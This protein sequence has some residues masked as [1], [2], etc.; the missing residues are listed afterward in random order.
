MKGKIMNEIL[1]IDDDELS[2]K[3]AKKWLWSEDQIF[4]FKEQHATTYSW[5]MTGHIIESA[6]ICGWTLKINLPYVSFYKDGRTGREEIP[7]QQTTVFSF[8]AYGY[9]RAIFLAFAEI[10]G[11]IPHH[12]LY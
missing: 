12:G 11:D 4:L 3:V 5:L 1:N 2:K 6:Y 7:P 9:T 8:E 10:P